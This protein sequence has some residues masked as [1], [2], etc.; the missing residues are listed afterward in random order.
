[1]SADGKSSQFGPNTQILLFYL[2]ERKT[3]S[4]CKN[5]QHYCCKV[6]ICAIFF[7]VSL[8]DGQKKKTLA[9]STP[10]YKYELGKVSMIGC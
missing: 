5:N 1:M 7:L 6:A 3:K 9:I 10:T 4:A 2:V 8:S